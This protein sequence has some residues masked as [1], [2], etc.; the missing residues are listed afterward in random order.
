MAPSVWTRGQ[1]T[2][3]ERRGA[4]D[5]TDVPAAPVAHG[6]NNPLRAPPPPAGEPR[7]RVSVS[8]GG[9]VTRVPLVSGSGRPVPAASGHR[10]VPPSRR[11]QAKQEN[12]YP[13]MATVSQTLS[14]TMPQHAVPHGPP[15]PVKRKK[16]VDPLISG[17]Q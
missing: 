1:G 14:L 10:Q 6:L 12:H 5:L 3:T 2:G 13:S 8:G 15:A 9:A 16:T 7:T 4:Y 17:H 11:C